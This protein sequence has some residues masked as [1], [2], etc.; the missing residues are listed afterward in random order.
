M[1]EYEYSIRATSVKP[2]I[3]YCQNNGYKFVSKSK[4]NRQVFENKENR[5]IISRITI[6]DNGNGDVCL[7]D[8]K[9]N[10]KG[11]DTFKVAKESSVL[12]IKKEDIDTVKNMLNVIGFEQSADNLRTRY[13]YEKD[14]VKFEI[15]EYI[16]PEMNVI[17]IEGEKE[18]V[19]KI[20]LDIK[21]NADFAK[22]IIK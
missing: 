12:Q 6:T 15:D 10:D 20:Y 14:G 13:V 5:K 8:F 17:G 3:E 4:E 22:Y 19:D 11:N 18:M 9:N 16:R 2:F 7:F 21:E 1:I